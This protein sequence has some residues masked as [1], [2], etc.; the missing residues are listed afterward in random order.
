MF[1]VI[2]LGNNRTVTMLDMVRGIEQALG[3]P[4]VLERLPEQPGDV[5]QTWASIQ[6]A[7]SLL[8]YEPRTGYADGLVRFVAWLRDSQDLQAAPRA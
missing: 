3:M 8:G 7:R 4:A 5:P 2:N 6:K 1:E